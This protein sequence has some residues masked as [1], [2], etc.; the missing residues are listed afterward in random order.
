MRNSPKQNIL[1]NKIIH[2]E[3]KISNVIVC[4]LS[5]IPKHKNRIS[6]VLCRHLIILFS[7]NMK[8]KYQNNT[9]LTE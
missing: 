6:F 7:R 5:V 9:G 4:R 1:C 2:H 3:D 8:K